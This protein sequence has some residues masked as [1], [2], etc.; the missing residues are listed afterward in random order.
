MARLRSQ[1]GRAC[2][3]YRY[4]LPAY[5]TTIYLGVATG[6]PPPSGWLVIAGGAGKSRTGRRVILCRSLVTAAA[7]T[8]GQMLMLRRAT[9]LRAQVTQDFQGV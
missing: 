4:Q 8:L 2:T 6:A 1:A 5:G 9:I 3:V 7:V